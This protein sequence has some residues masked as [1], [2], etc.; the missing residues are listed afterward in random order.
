MSEEFYNAAVAGEIDELRRLLEK[1][2][3]LVHSVDKWGFTALHGVAGEDKLETA[4]FLLHQG[5]NP[6]AKND[7]GITPL[8]LAA[9]PS[10][11]ELLVRR[12]AEVD[13]RSN[14]GRTPLLVQAAEAEGFDVMSA[15]LH[16]GADPKATDKRGQSALDVARAREEEDKIELLKPGEETKTKSWWKFWR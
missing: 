5:A 8:H 14:D 6:N 15:L 4:S 12:G 13:I 7:E 2:P 3:S 16:L 1:D 11:V 9:Y 10:M